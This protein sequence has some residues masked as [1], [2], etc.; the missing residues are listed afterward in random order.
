MNPELWWYLTRSSAL[1]AYMMLTAA[2]LWGIV[3]ASGLLGGRWAAWLLDLHR[4]L[5]AL[6]VF[7]IVAHL[8]TLVADSSVGFGL[9]DLLVPFASEW[10]PAPVALG[11]VALWLVLA[12]QATSLLVK[13]M[14]RRWWR[15][16]HLVAYAAFWLTSVHG[17]W[18]G[19]DGSRPVYVVASALA[20]VAVMFAASYRILVRRGLKT[21]P[22]ARRG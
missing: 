2:V 8:A 11:V 18:A 4:W 12:V 20:V 14:P 5:G 9:V 13:R 21:A 19:T 22:V 17:A 16:I 6:T 3:R 15:V 1:V 7:F 10:R